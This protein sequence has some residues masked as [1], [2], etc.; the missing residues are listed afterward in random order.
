MDYLIQNNRLFPL[1]TSIQN[2]ARTEQSFE[3]CIGGHEG[4]GYA[5]L[6]G[7]CATIT[8]FIPFMQPLAFAC[9]VETAVIAGVIAANCEINND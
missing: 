7:A 2:G 5:L 9:A 1:T 6:T 3:S 8:A 4:T